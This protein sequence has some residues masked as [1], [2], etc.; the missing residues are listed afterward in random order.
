MLFFLAVAFAN[1]K[2]FFVT[3][4]YSAGGTGVGVITAGVFLPVVSVMIIFG[5]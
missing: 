2:E 5:M 4:W 1:T 3:L